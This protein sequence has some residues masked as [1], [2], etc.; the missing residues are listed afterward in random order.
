[1][2]SGLSP[3]SEAIA[4]GTHSGHDVS[5]GAK[6]SD[7]HFL[8]SVI[9]VK[10]AVGKDIVSLDTFNKSTTPP[11]KIGETARITFSSE[12]VLVLH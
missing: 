3:D 8:G 1:L 10:A 9:R 2:R 5:L 12:D 6:I 7:V 4:L 11:P